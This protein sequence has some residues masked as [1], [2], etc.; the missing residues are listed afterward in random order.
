MDVLTTFDIDRWEGPF[1]A[2]AQ[3]QAVDA[4]ESGRLLYLPRLSFVLDQAER[5]FLSPQ[6]SDGKAKNVSYDPVKDDLRGTTVRHQERLALRHMMARYAAQARSLLESLVPSY[7]AHLSQARTSFRPVE[8]MGRIQSFKRDDRLLHTDAFPS[9]PS[10]GHRILRVFSNVNPDGQDRIWRVG[11][12][13]EAMARKFIGGLRPPLPGLHALLAVLRIT[14]GGRTLYD[15]FM[16]QLHDRVKKDQTYQDRAPQTSLAL[17][18]GSTWI[19]FTDQ[20]LHAALSGQYLFEQTFHLPVDAQHRLE[21][22]PLRVLERL[23]G[24]ALVG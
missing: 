18:P 15:S 17:K 12:P 14:K 22:A 20:V 4:L 6:W 13:F 1:P 7:R 3:A 24:R 21:L 2:E 19:V 5:H 16:L 10:R 9:R 11:E 8:V 23:T